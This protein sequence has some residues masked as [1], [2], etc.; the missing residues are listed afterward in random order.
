MTVPAMPT[1]VATIAA[2]V[3]VPMAAV[4][5][6]VPASVRAVIA[7]VRGVSV[8]V[9]IAIAVAKIAAVKVVVVIPAGLGRSGKGERH[10]G[11]EWQDEFMEQFHTE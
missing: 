11:D 2:V 9:R 6:R 3:I 7:I 10:Q 5:E 4:A 1:A 8:I